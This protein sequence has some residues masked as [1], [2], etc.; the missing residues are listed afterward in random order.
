MLSFNT[1]RYRWIRVLDHEAKRSQETGQPYFS[2]TLVGCAIAVDKSYFEHIGE[3]DE[4]LKV[5]GGENI[6]LAFRVWQCGGRVAT[7]MCSRVGHVFKNFPYKFDGDR[8]S[9]VSKN[10]MRVSETWMDG[11]RKYYYAT[12]RAY[13]FKRAE[14]TDDEL[15]S[16]AERIELRK[17]LKCKNFE[18]YMHNILPEV[19]MPPLNAN[20]Y[21]EIANLKTHACWELTDD[22]YIGMNYLCY[23]HKIIPE[24]YFHID[25]RNRLRFRDKCVQVSPPQ[26]AL[27]V[28]ESR[29]GGDGGASPED[30]GIWSVKNKGVTWGHLA[31]KIKNAQGQLEEFCVVQVT[32][33]FLKHH[34]KAQMPQLGRCEDTN[35]FQM[36]IFTYYF[37]WSQVPDRLH[38]INAVGAA[39]NFIR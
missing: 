28:T 10:L 3:F 12:S 11:Y 9:I 20:Y 24:N 33:V 38:K 13:D 34:Y 30:T 5:W 16:L 29:H 15:T 25:D 35:E 6:E 23:E 21:G 39:D 26:P 27:R 1:R 8:E 37:D 31:V 17:R 7:V 22:Y 14:L 36:W 19:E 4:G 32:N 18:W 2:P